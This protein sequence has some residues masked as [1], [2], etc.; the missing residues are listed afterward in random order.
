MQRPIEIVFED[1]E[2][3]DFLDKRIR[4]EA[5]KLERYFDHIT[6]MRVTF[7]KSHGRHR[8]GA[9]HARDD[10]VCHPGAC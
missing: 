9:T 2:P 7:A 3:S 6:G 4:E 8:K 1:I 5:D 10:F